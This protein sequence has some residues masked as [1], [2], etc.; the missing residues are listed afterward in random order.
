MRR[1]WLL[2]AVVGAGL[3]AALG[4]LVWMSIR[5]AQ[6]EDAEAS[7]RLEAARQQATNLALWRMDLALARLVA[8]E[9]MRPVSE[10]RKPEVPLRPDPRVLLHFDIDLTGRPFS[11]EVAAGAASPS[12]LSELWARVSRSPLEPAVQAQAAARKQALTAAPQSNQAIDQQLRNVFAT[13]NAAVLS[14]LA[15]ALEKV[16]ETLTPIWS[17]GALLLVRRARLDGRDH[18]F[19]CWLDWPTVR[20][21]LLASVRDL[22]P[23]ARL[24]PVTEP[25]AQPPNL[26]ASIPVRLVPG[27]PAIPPV[28][29]R[30]AR[31]GLMVA[32]VALALAVAALGAVVA[33]VIRLAERK[34]TF[35]S[36]V[37]HEL[38]TPLTTFRMYA[39]MLESG[40]APPAEMG[41][42]FRTLRSEA[43][44]LTHLV[45]NVLAWS[46]LERGRFGEPRGQVDLRNVLEQETPRLSEWAAR[47]GMNLEVAGGSDGALTVCGEPTA[48][49]QVLFNL[50]DNA[51]KYARGAADKRIEL[52]IRRDV[53]WV[54]L[55]VRDHGPGIPAR[56][57]RRMF[58]PFAKGAADAALSAPGIGLGL[59]LSRRLARAMGGDL[60]LLRAD[61]AGAEFELRLPHMT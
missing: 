28:A 29:S 13:Q 39:E 31:R 54:R 12:R 23:H 18:L 61:D 43:E 22:L 40:M 16:E 20:K 57:V 55:S 3:A 11:P 42:Y 53:D 45:E 35:A 34:A 47:A 17:D 41:S 48:I 5:L 51:C 52:A 50:V 27:E 14:P 59:P 44:R 6:L 9:G 21:G 2:G 4:A 7:V 38:R 30:S 49:G 26:L 25:G 36:A 1:R 58:H 8:E 32:W 56:I 19:G 60:V 33:G 37:T 10:Y 46:R 15:E 24:E